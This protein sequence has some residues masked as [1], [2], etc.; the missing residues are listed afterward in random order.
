MT[1]RIKIFVLAGILLALFGLVVGALAFVQE[2]NNDQISNIV[3]YELPLSRLVAE[4]DVDTDRYELVILRALREDPANSLNLKTATSTEQAIADELRA[5]VAT[6]ASLL[7]K[8]IQDPHYQASD[9]IDL[10][11]IAGS[12]KYLRRNLEDFLAVGEVTMNRLNA[13][14]REEAQLASNDFAK[15][16]QAFGPDLSEIR[17]DLAAVTERSTRAVL[18]R[19]T[20]D[21][22][23]SFAVFLAACA[24]GLGISAVGSTRVVSGLRQLVANTRAIESG[25]ETVPVLI[26]SRDEVGELALAFN[27]MVEELRT[28]ERIKDTF[29]KFLDPRIV[30]RLIDN[31]AEHAERRTLTVFFSDI[32]DFTAISEQLTASSVVNLLNSFLVRLHPSST[33]KRFHRQIHWRRCDGFLDTAVFS[34]RRPCQRCLLGGTGPTGGDGRAA[35]AAA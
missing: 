5:D 14:Q 6:A 20:L 16:V 22:Y 3:A 35:H 11:R 31:G 17:R 33:L 26:R 21:T 19:Q 23:L 34:R 25:Q 29:G 10:A 4:F 12:F 8:A 1:I 18:T 24:I 2:L 7:G 28:R 30:S 32:K 15:F 9:R 27:R 13:G